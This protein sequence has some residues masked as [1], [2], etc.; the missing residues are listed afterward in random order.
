MWANERDSSVA[1]E[2]EGQGSRKGNF[3]PRRGEEGKPHDVM[4][5]VFMRGPLDRSANLNKE[6]LAAKVKNAKVEKS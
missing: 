3:R 1:W 4:L 5:N 2:L 6:F